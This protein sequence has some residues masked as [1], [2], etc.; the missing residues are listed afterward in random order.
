M[1]GAGDAVGEKSPR[2]FESRPFRQ[3]R[4]SNKVNFRKNMKLT[5]SILPEKLGICH[6][7]KKSPIP[8][9]ALK[10]D[11]SSITRTSQ[12]LSIVYPQEKIPGGVLFEKDW[13]AFRLE[14]TVDMYSVGIIASLSKP[15]AEAGISIFNIS[16]Y[17]TNYILVEEKNLAKAKKI[18]SAFCNIK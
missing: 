10:G 1:R 2:E 3:G 9:W 18:L 6:F 4:L 17:E 13:R 11:F 5:L 15:L 8:D 12:E 7:D 14:S 16:T